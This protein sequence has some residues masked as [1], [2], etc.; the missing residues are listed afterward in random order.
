MYNFT[1]RM[2]TIANSTW[3]PLI[4]CSFHDCSDRRCEGLKHSNCSCPG[5]SAARRAPQTQLWYV[6]SPAEGISTQAGNTRRPSHGD[7]SLIR[8]LVI[9]W[10]RVSSEPSENEAEEFRSC[11]NTWWSPRSEVHTPP[12]RRG[13]Q[14][15]T[16]TL[17]LLFLKYNTRSDRFPSHHNI[18][19]RN[20]EVYES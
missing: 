11:R 16:Q 5:H 3:E 18:R 6:S 19:R 2:G 13:C 17:V 4:L 14:A 12:Y 9:W 10:H 7:T 20:N 8:T 15:L 1:G